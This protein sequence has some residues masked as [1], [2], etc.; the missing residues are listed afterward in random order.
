MKNEIID[1]DFPKG[2]NIDFT[3]YLLKDDIEISWAEGWRT[4]SFSLRGS[5]DRVEL[6]DK[7]QTEGD[8]LTPLEGGII[9]GSVAGLDGFLAGYL[10]LSGDEDSIVFIC[11]LLN[12]TVFYV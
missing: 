5:V 2:S 6:V 12:Q 1:G 11:F 7:S 10:S 4:S 9:G 3:N 8:G